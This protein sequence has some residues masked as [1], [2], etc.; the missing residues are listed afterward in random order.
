M[1]HVSDLPSYD[2]LKIDNSVVHCFTLLAENPAL[3]FHENARITEFT[4]LVRQL[5]DLYEKGQYLS[6]TEVDT[7]HTI[8][9]TLK[10]LIETRM[11]K[12]PSN[13]T[14]DDREDFLQELNT[15][16]ALD[17]LLF[18][19]SSNVPEIR[20]MATKILDTLAPAN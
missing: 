15:L 18:Y 14:D 7:H 8:L 3:K 6:K 4:G 16:G 13:P 10:R 12:M 2:Q 9:K 17:P 11:E 20:E 1:I 19:E 5:N